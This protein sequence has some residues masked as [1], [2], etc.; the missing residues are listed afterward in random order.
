MPHE[1]KNYRTHDDSDDVCEDY[2]DGD[3][4]EG[5]NAVGWRGGT[6]TCGCWTHTCSGGLPA[7][8]YLPSWCCHWGWLAP[9][10]RPEICQLEPTRL[11]MDDIIIANP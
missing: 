10:T 7:D 4:D 11:I 1:P 2:E 3:V 5:I 9:P 6:H 8:N